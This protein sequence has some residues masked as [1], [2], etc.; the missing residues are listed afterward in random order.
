M[1]CEIKLTLYNSFTIYLNLQI[2]C[3]CYASDKS[4]MSTLLSA[5]LSATCNALGTFNKKTGKYMIDDFTLNTVKD[6]IRYIRR[7]GEDHEIRMHLGKTKVLQT[8]LLP[9]LI[10]HWENTELFDVTLR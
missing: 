2:T 7:D 1:E 3:I 10:D 8:D 9:M 6:L 5:E 4:K